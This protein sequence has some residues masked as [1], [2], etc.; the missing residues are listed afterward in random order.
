MLVWSGTDSAD[1]SRGD[2]AGLPPRRAGRR[3]QL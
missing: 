3:S 1:H 2:P